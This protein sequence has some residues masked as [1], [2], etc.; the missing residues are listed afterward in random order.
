MVISPCSCLTV[1]SQ[2]CRKRED[3]E[4][5]LTHSLLPL[6]LPFECANP[7]KSIYIHLFFQRTDVT[8]PYSSYINNKNKLFAKQKQKKKKKE[9]E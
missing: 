2:Y 7:S 6:W 5:D 9:T 4:G 8:S 3:D 1:G